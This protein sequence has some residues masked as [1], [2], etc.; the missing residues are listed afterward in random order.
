MREV[1]TKIYN[2]SDH[3]YVWKKGKVYIACTPDKV[4]SPS[5]A[6]I[7]QERLKQAYETKTLQGE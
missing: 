3:V 6:G 7:S 4:V 5:M 2:G 1:K